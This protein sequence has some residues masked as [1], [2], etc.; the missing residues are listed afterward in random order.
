[1]LT[2]QVQQREV[3][4]SYQAT[5]SQNSPSQKS[6][7]LMLKP[8]SASAYSSFYSA[9]S[10]IATNPGFQE[11]SHRNPHP[12]PPFQSHLYP[13][14]SVQDTNL[15]SSSPNSM[16]VFMENGLKIWTCQLCN[17]SS[18]LS[19]NVK[20]HML[21]HTKEKPFACR[22][23]PYRASQKTNVKS[24]MLRKHPDLCTDLNQ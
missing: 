13:D 9:L 1:M 16:N 4:Y 5:G 14:D 7:A 10:D 17:Y 21:V 8:G 24:H 18:Q 12:Y 3:S 2:V 15:I 23:C 11:S 20:K 22:F 6:P 19:A